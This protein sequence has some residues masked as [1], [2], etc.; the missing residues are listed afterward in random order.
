MHDA[1]ATAGVLALVGGGSSMRDRK[2]NDK[3]TAAVG[4]GDS[5]WAMATARVRWPSFGVIDPAEGGKEATTT[6]TR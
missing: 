6:I 3:H 4:G 2:Y 1:S 5:F